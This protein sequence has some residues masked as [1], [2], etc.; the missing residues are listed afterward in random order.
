MIFRDESGS[1]SPMCSLR[2]SINIPSAALDLA[3]VPKHW[4]RADRA[5]TVLYPLADD[6]TFGQLRMAER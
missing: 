5:T 2:Q 3:T 1:R 6:A 4:V